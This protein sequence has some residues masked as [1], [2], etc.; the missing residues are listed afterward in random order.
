MPVRW[1]KSS[2]GGIVSKVLRQFQPT[3]QLKRMYKGIVKGVQQTGDFLVEQSRRPVLRVIG[4]AIALWLIKDPILQNAEVAWQIV[5]AK[6]KE[7]LPG[8][9][10]LT[11]Y[12]LTPQYH[13]RSLKSVLEG[14]H[15]GGSVHREG[16]WRGWLGRRTGNHRESGSSA[17][18]NRNWRGGVDVD[19][20][21]KVQ[22]R[23]VWE[24]AGAGLRRWTK[25]G[26]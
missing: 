7:W 13:K 9:Q 16:G 1:R 20:L 8:R 15:P 14:P 2:E 6:L 25:G 5:A 17:S 23:S 19:A 18:S 12:Q 10:K 3:R 21:S 4:G 24:K 22:E 11:S 26:Q